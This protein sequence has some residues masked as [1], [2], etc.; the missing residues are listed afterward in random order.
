M[1]QTLGRSTDWIPFIVLYRKL[2]IESD[3]VLNQFHVFHN[4]VLSRR[5][6]DVLN[7]WFFFFWSFFVFCRND[8]RNV[9]GHLRGYLR[10][11]LGVSFRT[12]VRLP[13]DVRADQK[14]LG[15]LRGDGST[16]AWKIVIKLY[17]R[18]L[19][20]ESRECVCSPSN[21]NFV[22]CAFV[23]RKCTNVCMRTSGLQGQVSFF[24]G[25][26]LLIPEKIK[27]NYS[28]DPHTTTIELIIFQL[29]KKKKKKPLKFIADAV[30]F[31]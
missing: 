17:V 9:V 30:Q 23:W 14:L 18:Y 11:R 12:A 29:I 3:Y 27:K 19:F 25:Q 24:S 16:P 21:C 31:L 20:R 7:F 4:S 10:G 1:I 8:L 28:F 22:H 13:V 5:P 15:E 2:A 6:P 26:T